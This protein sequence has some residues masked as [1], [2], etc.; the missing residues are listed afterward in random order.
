MEEDRG[1]SYVQASYDGDPEREWQRL[2][3][4]RTEFAV[5]LRA[6]GDHLPAPPARVLDVGGGPGR[7]AIHLAQ[8]G[9]EVTLFDLSAACLQMARERAA[10]A[11]A[12]LAEVT[13]GTATDLSHYPDEAFDAVLFMGPL[14]HLLE[15]DRRRQAMAEA[16]RVLRSG[17]MLFAAFITRYA[18]LRWAA[19][20]DP[21]WPLENRQM[22]ERV[23]EDGV[24]PPRGAPGSGF[25]AWF[26]H[27]NEVEPLL[28][29]AGLRLVTI[30]GVEGVVSMIEEGVNALRGEAWEL[31][32][33]LNYRLAADPSI[34]GCVEHLL[35]VAAKPG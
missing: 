29:G 4:H 27:P 3:R 5:T 11:G 18:G 21:L 19:V 13:Q 31:W 32:V 30:L 23:M 22:L 35:A 2:E 12:T 1:Q 16:V 26:A 24:Q 25:V 14:Y 10:A 20:N 34:H 9:Y 7:Y 17:G 15:A 6:L 33:D 8:Q 28:S